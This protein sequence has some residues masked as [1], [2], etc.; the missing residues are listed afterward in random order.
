MAELVEGEY[1]NIYSNQDAQGN[2]PTS[3]GKLVVNIDMLEA[4]MKV[5]KAQEDANEEI[6]VEI[7]LGFWVQ[8]AKESGKRY[9]RGRPSVYLKDDVP[10]QVLKTSNP[11]ADFK[12]DDIPF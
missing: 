12:D 10:N 6:A 5:A 9:L 4:M 11:A 7:G 2:K 1:F 3:S 8:T